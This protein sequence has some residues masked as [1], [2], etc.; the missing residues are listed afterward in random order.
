MRNEV[1]DVNV[2]TALLSFPDKIKSGKP[3][4]WTH[5][6]FI[7]SRLFALNPSTCLMIE[8]KRSSAVM[9]A[10]VANS[11]PTEA[12]RQAVS[13]RRFKYWLWALLGAMTLSVI[14]Y[15]EVRLFRRH[16]ERTY[17]MSIP[18]L[19]VPHVLGGLTALLS[20]PIQ[21][22]S[23]IRKKY[24]Q[25]HRILGR[26]YVIGVFIAAPL[27]VVLAA[28][29]HDP[30]IIHFVGA[31]VVQASAWVITTGAAFLTA[32]NG[33]FQQHF[34][35]MVRSYGVTFTF[36]ATRVL[37]PIPLWNKHSEAGF[38]MEIIVITFM[39]VL[40][41]DIGLNWRQITTRKK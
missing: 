2:L 21:F 28:N 15:A 27:A 34:E 35:W 25:F 24:P 40:I 16:R 4:G 36:V 31:N 20:G 32:R 3:L 8:S 7:P 10:T 9:P 5:E 19:I 12:E 23:R 11:L 22:S 18:W 26:C 41:P 30:Q 39:A 37:Q 29:H 6:L 1:R 17:L 33:H 13:R 14:L 38:A